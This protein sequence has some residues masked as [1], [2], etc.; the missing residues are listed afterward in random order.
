MVRAIKERPRMLV[1]R[2]DGM[3]WSLGAFFQDS[4]YVHAACYAVWALSCCRRT[5]LL[6]RLLVSLF[7][8][9]C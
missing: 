1:C 5:C 4:K 9:R 6:T 2:H 7:V 8:L 3:S